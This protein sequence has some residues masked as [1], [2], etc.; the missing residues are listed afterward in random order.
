MRE[1]HVDEKM[2]EVGLVRM[3]RGEVPQHPHRHH[4]KSVEHWY[5]QHGEREC[6]ESEVPRLKFLDSTAG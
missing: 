2:V 1:A 3:E 4:P 5:A 6:D